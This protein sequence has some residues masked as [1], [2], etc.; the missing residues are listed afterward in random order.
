MFE[1]DKHFA[2]CS[3]PASG[4]RGYDIV[5]L[6]GNDGVPTLHYGLKGMVFGET[7]FLNLWSQERPTLAPQLR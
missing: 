2:T 7:S 5:I 1:Y 3:D 6:C 4:G